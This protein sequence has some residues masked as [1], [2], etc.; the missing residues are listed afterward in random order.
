[1]AWFPRAFAFFLLR[2]HVQVSLSR[3]AHRPTVVVHLMSLVWLGRCGAMCACI[4]C[5]G[6]LLEGLADKDTVVRW[7]AAKGLGR[8]AGRLTKVSSSICSVYLDTL[9][10]RAAGN[11]GK[12]VPSSLPHSAYRVMQQSR[13]LCMRLCY[14]CDW[15]A[16]GGCCTDK[17]ATSGMTDLCRRWRMK[18]WTL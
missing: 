8:I 18:C 4:C 6:I 5:A 10:D 11:L 15:T 13:R 16:E 9:W 17:I 7:S 12:T 1:M 14:L 3:A 2:V